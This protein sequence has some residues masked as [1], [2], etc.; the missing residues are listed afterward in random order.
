MV[1]LGLKAGDA[2]W[3]GILLRVL[4][5]ALPIALLLHA[6]VTCSAMRRA[7]RMPDA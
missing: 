6:A 4:A 2:A 5:L 1:F 3:A 7:G